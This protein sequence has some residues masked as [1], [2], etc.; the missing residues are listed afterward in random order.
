M[1]TGFFR[2]NLERALANFFVVIFR[3]DL[4]PSRSVA[5]EQHF[6]LS[7]WKLT[8]LGRTHLTVGVLASELR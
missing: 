6:G 8:S 5:C 1:V 3:D 4:V 2:V 7:I